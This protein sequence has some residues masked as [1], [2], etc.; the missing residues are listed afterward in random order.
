M[1]EYNNKYNNYVNL[2]EEKL[3]V[4]SNEI[5]GDL[6]EVGQAARYSLFSGGKRIRGVLTVAVSDLL[7]GDLDTALAFACSIEMLHCYSLIHDDL[8]AMDNSDM[9]RGKASCHVKYGQAVALLAGDALLTGAF[10]QLTKCA[11][12]SQVSDAVICLSKSA[13]CKGMIYGQELDIAFEGKTPSESDLVSIH[14]NKTGQLIIAASMLGAIAANANTSQK[15]FISS[16]SEKIGM[17][18]QIIDDIL[19]ITST[20]I[21]LGKP[22]GNDA[23]LMKTTFATLNGIDYAKQRA[24]KLTDEAINTIDE[25]GD[26]SEFLKTLAKIMLDRK[27]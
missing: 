10:E 6:S 13:G 7:D 4:Y 12:Q 17:V 3:K 2:I 9:R 11:G 19:D 20:D 23:A 26:K 22:S 1:I 27:N 16:Y 5:F 24:T 15:E 21:E 14:S 25:F 8:P 18:F